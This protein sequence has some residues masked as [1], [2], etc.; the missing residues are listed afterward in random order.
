MSNKTTPI[1][2][3]PLSGTPCPVSTKAKITFRA[4][5]GYLH[6]R[7]AQRAIKDKAINI[8][9]NDLPLPKDMPVAVF[10]C[11]ACRSPVGIRCRAK[12]SC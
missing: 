9:T 2:S 10:E 12:I 4:V 11:P 8:G 7:L 1:R 6:R 5:E 3:S